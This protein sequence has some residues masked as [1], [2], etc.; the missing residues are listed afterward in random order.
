M[1]F[2]LTLPERGQLGDKL[3]LVF[4]LLADH[5]VRKPAYTAHEADSP[6]QTPPIN[7]RHSS[8][9]TRRDALGKPLLSALTEQRTERRRSGRN[10]PARTCPI[11]HSIRVL[12]NPRGATA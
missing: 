10:H 8:I 1:F 6:E 11:S 9:K 2:E 7:L 3:G 4:L 12:G 5:V